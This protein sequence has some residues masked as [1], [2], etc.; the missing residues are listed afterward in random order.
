M[1]ARS[2]YRDTEIFDH[3]KCRKEHKAEGLSLDEAYVFLKMALQHFER[4]YICIDALDECNDRERKLLLPFMADLMK[5]SR[6]SARIFIIG[7][8]HMEKAIDGSFDILSRHSME[9][10]ANAADVRGY[11][12]QQLVM[13]DCYDEMDDDF[14]EEITETIVGT[15]D[16]M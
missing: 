8:P 3:L 5:V 10:K 11:I 15:V 2:K 16:G 12:I 4:I 1:K 6:D 9:L 14:K 7:R 13:D